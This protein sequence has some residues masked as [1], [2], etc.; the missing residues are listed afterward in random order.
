MLGQDVIQSPETT[1]FL[2]AITGVHILYR[3]QKGKRKQN[4]ANPLSRLPAEAAELKRLTSE[5]I[6]EWVDRIAGENG[7]DTWIREI[8]GKV[9][10]G[11]SEPNYSVRDGILYYRDKFCLG[12]VSISGGVEAVDVLLKQ[13][14]QLLHELRINL[15]E[16]MEKYADLKR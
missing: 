5:V 4:K 12:N 15:H 7:S 2:D 8:V 3:L 6:S 13:G 10:L 16:R 1:V 11:E 14:D 9:N